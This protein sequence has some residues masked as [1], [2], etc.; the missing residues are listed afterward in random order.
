LSRVFRLCR[1]TYPPYNGEGARR[2][3][4]RWNSKGVRV[5]YLSE[6]RSLAVLEVLVHL[7][8]SLPDRYVL[9]QAEFSDELAIEKVDPEA[10]PQNWATLFPEEQATT[11]RLGDEWVRAQR[12]AILAVP[13][14]I[15]GEW[16]YVLNPEHP[17]F[18][19]ISF[20]DPIPFRFD[21][22]LSALTNYL[23]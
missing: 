6:N 3:G 19:R 4:G 16:N 1:N 22:R 8:P 12:T 5:L 23:L 11:R 17:D 2:A 21:L 7:S 18:K 10:L 15:S 13:S 14:V 20:A 9:G